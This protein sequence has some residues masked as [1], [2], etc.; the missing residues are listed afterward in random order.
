[1]TELKAVINLYSKNSPLLKV[2]YYYFWLLLMALLSRAEP[3]ISGTE[4]ALSTVLLNE[5]I[6]KRQSEDYN[7]TPANL[8]AEER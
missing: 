1:M 3:H 6:L 2:Y 7:H 5:E 8:S 4:Q